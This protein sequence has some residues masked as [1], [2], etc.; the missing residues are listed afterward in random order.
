MKYRG[1]LNYDFTGTFDD[2]NATRLKLALR[3]TGWLHVET[4]AFIIETDDL[5][6]VWR[7][8]ELVA[9][10]VSS[11]GTLSALTYHVQASDDFLNSM[12][13]RTTLNPANA[14]TDIM[15]KPFPIVG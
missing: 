13:I 10:Q 15:S 12:E 14:L 3:E 4:S 7:G 2:N 1:T 8:L 5:S 6:R 11:I 9:K